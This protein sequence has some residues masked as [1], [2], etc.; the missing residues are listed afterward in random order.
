MSNVLDYLS[1]DGKKL[2]DYKAIVP[3]DQIT[4]PGADFVNRIFIN[5]DRGSRW[6]NLPFRKSG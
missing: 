6:K 5:S 1:A 4:L 3:K 2:L